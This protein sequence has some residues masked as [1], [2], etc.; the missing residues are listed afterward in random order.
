MEL[1][2]AVDA[3]AEEIDD[4]RPEAARAVVV[5]EQLQDI[6]LAQERNV[7][8]LIDLVKE[9]ERILAEMKDN[10]R[11]RIVQD[12]L[13]IVVRSDRNNS[14]VL[15]E[16]DVTLLFI[17]VKVHLGAYG[18]EI[19]E[20]KYRKV[21]GN[22]ASVA[23]TL[24]IARRLSDQYRKDECGN[25][26][27]HTGFAY[28]DTEDE[29]DYDMFTTTVVPQSVVGGKRVSL[30]A[31]SRNH[32]SR[33]DAARERRFTVLADSKAL[34]GLGDILDDIS[35]EVSDEDSGTG[36][37]RPARATEDK[38]HGPRRHQGLAKQKVER[39][40]ANQKESRTLDSGIH[41]EEHPRRV[42]KRDRVQGIYRSMRSR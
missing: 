17:K 31:R 5:E 15:S 1:E 4:L 41:A 28:E 14:G 36:R 39:G 25:L 13:G 26:V 42:R 19:D 35:E 24:K 16:K 34:L 9:N 37:G 30:C 2:R 20:Q 40:L 11:Q 33:Q 27:R 3:L 38:T 8:K 23:Q 18:V 10:L 12:I 6:S 22:G 29:D 21:M 7:D 32:G